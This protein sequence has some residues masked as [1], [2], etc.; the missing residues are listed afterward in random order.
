MLCLSGTPSRRISTRRQEQ[1]TGKELRVLD[2][3]SNFSLSVYLVHCVFL[4][5]M[6]YNH[7]ECKTLFYVYYVDPLDMLT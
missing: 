1:L 7:V 5:C 2:M 4:Q 3:Q 6:I